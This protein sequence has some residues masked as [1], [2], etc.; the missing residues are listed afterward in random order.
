MPPSPHTTRPSLSAP[1]R[2]FVF[3]LLFSYSSAKGEPGFFPALSLEEGEAVTV[4][5]GQAPFVHAP[6][7]V[8][9]A[10][11]AARAGGGGAAVAQP[12][13]TVAVTAEGEGEDGEDGGPRVPVDLE[14]FSCATDLA[15]RF[16]P[17]RLK[18]RV[19]LVR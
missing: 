16:G 9:K 7:G 19:S 12:R 10:V 6:P 1:D 5:L 8:S 13:L 2:L 15:A 11:I 17:N 3:F 4:N 18:V 14:E